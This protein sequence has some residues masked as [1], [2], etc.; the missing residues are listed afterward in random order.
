MRF[1]LPPPAPQSLLAGID[2]EERLP[3]RPARGLR[4]VSKKREW[5]GMRNKIEDAGGG[6]N[7]AASDAGTPSG[8]PM[9]TSTEPPSVSVLAACSSLESVQPPVGRPCG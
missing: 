4:Q 2:V 5:A 8:T 9:P 1:H 7:A 6:R 3:R